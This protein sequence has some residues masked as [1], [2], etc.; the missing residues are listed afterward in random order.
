MAGC[1]DVS[2]CEALWSCCLTAADRAVGWSPG[3][4]GH[5]LRLHTALLLPGAGEG[6]LQ[7][8]WEGEKAGEEEGEG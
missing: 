3:G 6:A 4:P 2:E 8:E 5:T 1:E 7:V